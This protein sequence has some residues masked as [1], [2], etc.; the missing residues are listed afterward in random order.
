[1]HSLHALN[2]LEDGRMV[3]VI[4][5]RFDENQL[6]LAEVVFIK[7]WDENHEF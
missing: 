3:I 2:L 1:M 4:C 5:F 7:K 6:S